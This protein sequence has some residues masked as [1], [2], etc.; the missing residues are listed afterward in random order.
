MCSQEI[1]I[2]KLSL[3]INVNTDI[4]VD[5]DVYHTYKSSVFSCGIT[6]V[7]KKQNKTKSMFSIQVDFHIFD[8]ATSRA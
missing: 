5:I 3:D 1:W 8:V 2:T 4:G 6:M 7:D